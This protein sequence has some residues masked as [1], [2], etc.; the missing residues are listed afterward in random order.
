MT[1]LKADE[2]KNLEDKVHLILIREFI[3]KKEKEKD[4]WD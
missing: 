4:D 3:P 2:K 1:K